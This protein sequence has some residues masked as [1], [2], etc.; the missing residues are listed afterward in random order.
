M[1]TVFDL[2]GFPEWEPSLKKEENRWIEVIRKHFELSCFQPFESSSVENINTLLSKGDITEEIFSVSR[3]QDQDQQKEKYALHYD[4]TVPFARYISKR[5][6]Q[7]FFPLKRYQIQKVWRGERPQAGRFREFYQCDIDILDRQKITTASEFD[8]VMTMHACIRELIFAPVTFYLNNRKII[9]GFLE[10]LHINDTDTILRII[11]KTDK[12]GILEASKKLEEILSN[13]VQVTDI[14]NF[15]QMS[16]IEVTEIAKTDSLKNNALF[17]AGLKEIKEFMFLGQQNGI[18]NINVNLGMVRGF[19]YYTG[20]IFEVKFDEF[21]AFGTIISGGSYDS[22]IKELGASESLYGFGMSFGLTRIF[23]KFIEEG[24][25]FPKIKKEFGDVLIG[26]LEDYSDDERIFILKR[27]RENGWRV[28]LFPRLEKIARQI[29]FATDKGYRYIAF[30]T[31]DKD[32][33]EV[34]DLESGIQSVVTIE[35]WRHVSSKI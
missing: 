5:I 15:I 20:N 11:D 13:Q 30:T 19:N 2:K 31:K 9:T 23:S 17:N 10:S 28:D 27:L 18:H 33:I 22:L 12:I 1:K 26:F 34:K 21:P 6:R 32:V 14:I 4:L 29:K 35:N 8:V 3:Y 25:I 7:N 24:I 16:L